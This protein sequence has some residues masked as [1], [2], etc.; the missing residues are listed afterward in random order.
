MDFTEEKTP[1]G[2]LIKILFKKWQFLAFDRMGKSIYTDREGKSLL[3]K[4]PLLVFLGSTL[5]FKHDYDKEYYL[6]KIRNGEM[7]LPYLERASR[8]TRYL[9]IPVEKDL[10]M[11]P[12]RM[13]RVND[14]AEMV[15]EYDASLK[16]DYVIIDEKITSNDI[17]IVLNR[18][19]IEDENIIPAPMSDP[20]PRYLDDPDLDLRTNLN[21]MSENPVY[22]AIVHLRSSDYS[23]IY[24]L[25]LDFELTA[26][27]TEYILNFI[28]SKI[29]GMKESDKSNSAVILKNLQN[30]YSFY[31]YL[32]RKSD[33]DVKKM[34]TECRNPKQMTSYRT[35]ISKVKVQYP[36]SEE[37]ILFTEYENILLEKWDEIK[38][39]GNLKTKSS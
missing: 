34:I 32:L 1:S 27:D 39:S 33:D 7:I 5:D 30:I 9:F 25:L 2:K 23:R 3:H 35:L 6:L 19:K 16:P 38:H 18:Y 8:K 13:I 31:H 24:Q 28:N 21:I 22:L 12:V 14:V 11:I 15:K 37:Q 17:I 20:E 36:G 26:L 4:I 29:D 10:D